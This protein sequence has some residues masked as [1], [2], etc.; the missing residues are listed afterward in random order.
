[1]KR[2]AS[3]GVNDC[4]FHIGCLVYAAPRD[5][6]GEGRLELHEMIKPVP[7]GMLDNT[8]SLNGCD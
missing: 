3:T 6:H 7:C 2:E 1:M 5:K 8:G 4:S